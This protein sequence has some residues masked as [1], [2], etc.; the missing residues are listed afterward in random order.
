M[1]HRDDKHDQNQGLETP[2]TAPSRGRVIGIAILTYAFIACTLYFFLYQPS[3][4]IEEAAI[5]QELTATPL[6]KSDAY[7]KAIYYTSETNRLLIPEQIAFA[8]LETAADTVALAS[9]LGTYP[10]IELIFIDPRQVPDADTSWVRQQYDAGKIIVGLNIP[11]SELGDWLGVTT[12]QLD[13]TEDE[14]RANVVWISAYYLAEDGT[15]KELV[16]PYSQFNTMLSTVHN[17]D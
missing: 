2:D 4:G 6:P 17:L 11:H 8:N 13:L 14:A 10:E 15:A 1:H 9:T 5:Q 16:A 3:E 7:N 12:T